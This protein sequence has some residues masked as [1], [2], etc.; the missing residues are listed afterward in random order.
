MLEEFDRTG[1]VK[2]EGAFD[3]ASAALMQATVWRELARR[4]GIERDEPSTWSRHEPTGLKSTKKSRA[5]APICGEAVGAVLDRLFGVGRWARPEHFG[6]V[7][8]T[9]PNAAEWRVPHRIWHSD[10]P[11]TLPTDQLAVVKLWALFDDVAVGGGGTPQ[12]AGSHTLFERYVARTGERDYKRA[13]FGFLK[14]D[15]WFHALT[16]DDTDPG[17]N[18]KFLAGTTIDDVAVGVVECT[19]RAGDVYVTHPWVFHSI[20]N[21]ATTRPRLMRSVA[22]RRC[23]P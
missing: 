11:A 4:H 20:A 3:G 16:R 23:A 18:E 10:F 5:F 17:R 2:I 13:K 8:V 6:N 19:G 15:P 21:N 14:S 12:L 22:I 9:M 7:L 1:I